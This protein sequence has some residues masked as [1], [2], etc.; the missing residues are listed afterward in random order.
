MHSLH[1]APLRPCTCSAPQLGKPAPTSSSTFV[2]P[3]IELNFEPCTIVAQNAVCLGGSSLQRLLASRRAC[4]SC[5]WSWLDAAQL[6][7]WRKHQSDAACAIN[8]PVVSARPVQGAHQL[9]CSRGPPKREDRQHGAEAV[10]LGVFWRR[11]AQVLHQAVQASISEL[12]ADAGLWCIHLGGSW[13]L[14]EG[15]GSSLKSPADGNEVCRRPHG[16]KR[17]GGL[18][19]G[20]AGRVVGAL[21]WTGR[22][23]CGGSDSPFRREPGSVCLLIL[24]AWVALFGCKAQVSS[25][26][27]VGLPLCVCWHLQNGWA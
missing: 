4:E 10:A 9:V 22:H 8:G 2:G 16:W 12:H 15:A 11:P 3:V 27:F 21:W 6:W 23:S 13:H 24:A 7:G 5:K 14:A 1:P 20:C 25:S 19:L 18:G 26:A 17:A